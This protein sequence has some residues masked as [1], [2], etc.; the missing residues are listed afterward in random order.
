MQG[1][2]QS[3]F[4]NIS[5]KIS[6]HEKDISFV[7][8][9]IEGDNNIIKVEKLNSNIKGKIFISIYGNNNKVNI[10]QGLWVGE[11]GL[12][13]QIGINS[14]CHEK[15]SNSAVFIGE[16]VN[17]EGAKILTD[18]SKA[19]INIGDN[20]LFSWG[21]NLF[22]TDAHPIYDL[23][24]KQILNRAYNM[25]IG[26]HVWIGAY[27]TLLKNVSV[28]QDSIIGWGSVVTGQY[29]EKNVIIAGNPAR[30]VRRNVNWHIDNSQPNLT[31]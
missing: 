9:K 8:I 29:T 4:P 25:E 16:K 20:C 19:K 24:T 2:Q 31:I 14:W 17:I 10:K 22:H 27:A 21:I 23:N 18:Q 3:I 15:V 6:I 7:S 13:I 28:K 26:N 11:N 5:N 1:N 12:N 30:I